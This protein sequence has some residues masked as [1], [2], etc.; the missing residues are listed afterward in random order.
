ME[1]E[2]RRVLEMLQ[3]GRI[4][5]AQAAELLEALE[6]GGA[7][8]AAPSR[9][10]TLH[11]TVSDTATGRVRVNVNIPLSLVDVAS[12]LGMNLGIKRAPELA[13]IDFEQIVEA[14]RSGAQGKIVDIVDDDDRQHV[15]VSV[16]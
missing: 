6:S 9:P 15:V 8:A 3:A 5:S 14:L 1:Q 12:R 11:I 16:E 13:N 2:T 10:R 7:S 4:T